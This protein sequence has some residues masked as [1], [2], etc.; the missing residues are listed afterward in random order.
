MNNDPSSK[1]ADDGPI[2]VS[3]VVPLFNEQENVTA[4]YQEIAAVMSSAG[5]TN[6]R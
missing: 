6:R 4:L 5:A 2:E 1:L 3:I